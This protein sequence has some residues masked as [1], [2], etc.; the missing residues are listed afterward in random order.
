VI[1]PTKPSAIDK[2]P[3]KIDEFRGRTGQVLYVSATPD[4]YEMEQ[5]GGETI[6]RLEIL[7]NLRQGVYDVLVGINLPREGLDF[8]EVSLVAILDADKQGFLRSERSLIQTVGRAARNV[9]GRVIMY[10]D[11]ISDA[12]RATI[13]ETQ[14]RREIQLAYNQEHGI[15][16]KSVVRSLTDPFG[17]LYE[18]D[19]G[20]PRER[21]SDRPRYRTKDEAYQKV[22][23]LE[24][25]MMTLAEALE[26]EK[27][28]EIRDQIQ[29]IKAHALELR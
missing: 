21:E 13:D 14:R 15:T 5:T 28:A 1:L 29:D 22:A 26:F 11:R 20:T 4:F 24:K 17:Q 16:P 8:P 18:K 23:E 19:Y 12:M 25:Q 3:V 10:A 2:R 9:D 7:A 6:E 27:A